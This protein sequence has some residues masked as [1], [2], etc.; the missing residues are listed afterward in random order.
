MLKITTPTAVDK[1]VMC[2]I[3]REYIQTKELNKIK[4]RKLTASNG[5]GLCTTFSCPNPFKTELASELGTDKSVQGTK[6][7]GTQWILNSGVSSWCTLLV[8]FKFCNEFRL[9]S[10]KSFRGESVL[11]EVSGREGV[12]SCPR[13][14]WVDVVL[15]TFSTTVNNLNRCRPP[16]ALT[17]TTL[18]PPVLVYSNRHSSSRDW[19]V[20]QVPHAHYYSHENPLLQ[21][22]HSPNPMP[23]HGAAA[24]ATWQD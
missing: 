8:S 18:F 7:T 13:E 19:A 5:G 3:V 21:L 4:R 16:S 14:V 6:V 12:Y 23:V 15:L 10:V 2:Y 20:W 24:A 17:W 22:L 1:V 9:E 11:L